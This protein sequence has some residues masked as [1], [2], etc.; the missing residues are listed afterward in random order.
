MLG[1]A[2]VAVGSFADYVL[3]VQILGCDICWDWPSSQW[4][5]LQTMFC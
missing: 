2:F 3:L 5:V 4:E 1:L